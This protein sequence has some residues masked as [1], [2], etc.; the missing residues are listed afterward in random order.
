MEKHCDPHKFSKT[1]TCYIH[2]QKSVAWII[3]SEKLI[4]KYHFNN[5]VKLLNYMRT[6]DNKVEY[7]IKITD[8]SWLKDKTNKSPE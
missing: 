6:Y 3:T 4:Q 2:W 7:H 8:K 5:S 1:P